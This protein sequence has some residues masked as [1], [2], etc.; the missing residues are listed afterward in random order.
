MTEMFHPVKNWTN[1]F[2]VFLP[3]QKYKRMDQKPSS[4]QPNEVH[5]LYLCKRATLSVLPLNPFTNHGTAR[6]NSAIFMA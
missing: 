6:F 4:S 3:P 1:F 5:C 2:T